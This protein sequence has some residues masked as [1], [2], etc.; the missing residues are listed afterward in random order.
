[1]TPIHDHAIRLA[2][3]IARMQ[4]AAAVYLLSEIKAGRHPRRA[5]PR[6]PAPVRQVFTFNGPVLT[7]P[8][9][10]AAIF[11]A[12]ASIPARRGSTRPHRPAPPASRLAIARLLDQLPRPLTANPL[13]QRPHCRLRCGAGPEG[14]CRASGALFC[15][16]PMGPIPDYILDA[17]G[18]PRRN[19][20][21]KLPCHR[22]RRP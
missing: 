20:H 14:P 18:T 22:P 8:A 11:N 7:G 1:M 5:C 6:E 2:Y 3:A 12:L 17:P 10:T 21:V 9:D 15:K 16:P 19:D 13:H 4:E